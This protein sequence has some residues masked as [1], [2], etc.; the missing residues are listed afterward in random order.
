MSD[1]CFPVVQA[2]ALEAI[3]PEHTWLVEGLWPLHGVGVLGGA[4][5]CSKTWLGLDLAVSVAS[6]TACLGRF[7]TARQGRALVYLAEDAPPMVRARL[8]GLCRH[9]RLDLAALPLD[10]I[11]A[12]SLRLDLE[13]DRRRLASTIAQHQPALLLLDPFIRMH[14]V[15]ENDA[16][17]VAAILDELRQLQ[18]RHDVAICIV[19]H[20]RKNGPA[21]NTGLALRGSVDFYAWADVLLVMQRRREHLVL[22]VEHRSAPAP[23]PLSLHLTGS[24]AT[25]H[26]EPIDD[27]PD[28][29]PGTSARAEA[30]GLEA[31][32]LAALVDAAQPLPRDDL[33]ARLRVRNATLGHA[34]TRL[35]RDGRIER[36]DTGWAP[37]TQP[38]PI[39]DSRP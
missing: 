21:G 15:D 39:P 32:V 4:P 28:P 35:L 31:V 36:H 26:L 19:H 6:A 24:D 12:P 13:R 16:G 38:D 5:K 18:R 29:E 25:V 20:A 9:R 10:V 3:T 11:T 37:V 14:R 1:S 2:A 33:R 8:E 30:D 27:E 34:L 23:P 22:T 17:Q 7:P